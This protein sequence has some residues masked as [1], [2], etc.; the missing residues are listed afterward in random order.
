[1]WLVPSLV[2]AVAACL[3][4]AVV[5]GTVHGDGVTSVALG[6]G[7]SVAG[8]APALVLLLAGLRGCWWGWRPL[9]AGASGARIIAALTV[10]TASVGFVLGAGYVAATF[11]PKFTKLPWLA[12]L[13]AAA[14]AATAIAVS[15][16]VAPVAV[17]GV[18][19]IVLRVRPGLSPRMAWFAAGS[20]AV[21]VVA[22]AWLAT[23]TFLARFELGVGAYLAGFATGAALAIA[24]LLYLRAARTWLGVAA[25]VSCAAAWGTARVIVSS[26]PSALLDA[27]SALPVNGQL[28]ELRRDVNDL[29]G[30]V[31]ATIPRL[32]ERTTQHPDI[33]LV[34]VDSLRADRITPAL[35]PAIHTLASG[36]ASFE[37]AYAPSTFTRGSL[38]S[39]MTSLTPGRVRGRLIDFA[40]KLDPRHVLL[41]ERLRR[42]GYATRGFLC[43]AHHFGGQFDLGLDRGLDRVLYDRSGEHLAQGA[44]SFF[45]DAALDSAPRFAWLHT[46]EPHMWGAYYPGAIYGK[47][48]GPRYDRTVASVD[49]ALAPLFAAIRARGRPTIVIVTSDHGEGLGEHG[50]LA[51]ADMPYA[52]L[53]R[54]PLLIATPGLPPMKIATPISLV[55]LGD[56]VLELAGYTAQAGD[57]PSFSHL[58]TGPARP[59]DGEV[60]SVVL[61]DRAMPFT[62]H[63]LIS[64]DHH[65]IER[66]GRAPELY[67]LRSDPGELVNI[68]TRE[69]ARLADLQ[70]R[71]AARRLHDRTPPFSSSQMPMARTQ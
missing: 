71:L 61:K 26:Q 9:I 60:Y 19:A 41:A 27:W 5:E 17:R 23:R 21:A 46:Y 67:D 68:A 51:H 52:S 63:S 25:I 39:M 56:T 22:M 12:A 29:R 15:I 34:T 16:A 59:T 54:V 2:T 4:G 24:A 11:G 49:R 10:A 47:A 55:A 18:T 32:V 6:A 58:L 40:L 50:A 62:A 31:L 42:A 44:I 69:P 57:V 1:M 37:H 70:R 65:L 36:G 33:L 13:I 7:E 35:A 20:V 43:C 53:I 3:G 8:A 28:I 45:S 14:G 64:G 48:P 38:P 30:Q 66:E